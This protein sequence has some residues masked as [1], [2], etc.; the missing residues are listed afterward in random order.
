[1]S[2]QALDLRR[3][4]Q[5]VRRHRVLVGTVAVLGILAGGAYAALKPPMLTSTALVVLPQAA[6]SAQGAAAN[7]APDPFM[8]TQEVIATSNP[9]LSDALPHVRPAMSLDELRHQLQLGSLTSYIISISA[10]GKVAA[11]AEATANAVADSYIGYISSPG[12]RSGSCRRI[13]SSR[14]QV[15]RDRRR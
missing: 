1:M 13:C 8:A 15:Q 3:S 14:R 9:V 12:S 2:D 4:A 7:V 11:D 10:K 6:Q 5:I